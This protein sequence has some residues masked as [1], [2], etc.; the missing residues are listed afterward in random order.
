MRNIVAVLLTS[1]ALLVGAGTSCAEPVELRCE[2]LVNPLG[3]DAA[4]PRFSWQS[5]STER[6]WRQTAYEILVSTKPELLK[7]GAADV[8]ESG[9]VKSG[10]SLGIV[11]AGPKLAASRRYYWT[12]RVWD[13]HGKESGF[14]PAAW[15]ETGLLTESGWKAQWISWND[16]E[17]PA[18]R[19]A[20]QWIWMTTTGKVKPGAGVVFQRTFDLS[21]YPLRAAMFLTARSEFELTVNG[22][23]VAR[24]HNWI[25]FDRQ[26]IGYLLHAG[27]NVVEVMVKTEEPE[28]DDADR[29]KKLEQQPI[30]AGLLKITQG[31]GQILRLGTDETWEVRESRTEAG[32]PA[33]V[34]NENE[35]KRFG[36]LPE[37]LPRPAAL[38]RREFELKK[39]VKSARMYATALGSYRLFA[40]GRRVGEGVLTP[41]SSDY[42][43]RVLY[44]TYDVTGLLKRGKN[45]LGAML[46]DGWYG[47]GFTWEGDHYFPQPD[48][49]LAQLEVEYADGT[50]EQI[51][52]DGK[53][54]AAASAILHSEIYAG[55]TYDARLE[56]G[57]WDAAGFDDKKWSA[58]NV[59]PAAAQ[60]AVTSQVDAAA[61]VVKSLP[62][63]TVTTM[64]DGSYVFDLGQNMVGWTKLKVKGPGGTAVRL[65]YAEVLN[66]DG[67]IYRENLRNAD[68]TDLYVLRGGETEAYEPHFTFHGFRYVE[69]NGYPGKPGLDAIEGRVV[70]SL[71]GAGTG[72]LNTSSELVNRMWAI[73]L[74]GQRGNFV[75]IP[76]DCPQRDERLGW[77]GDAAAF[78]RTGTYNF[79]IEAFSEKWLQDVRDAQLGNGSFTNVSPNT[80]P[81][82]KDNGAPGWGDA[83][84]IVPYTTWLQ[85]GNGRAIEENWAAME[86]WMQFIEKANP[87]YLR[88]HALG[89]NYSD[90]LAPDERTPSD[91]VATAYWALVAERMEEMARAAGKYEAEK[92]YAG[93][94]EKI[95]AAY[96]TAYVKSDGTVSGGTQTAYVLT[97]QMHLA[98]NELE[99]VMVNNLVK[100]IEARGEHLSTGFL[101]TPF[102]LFVLSDHGRSDVA[103]KL[104]L[105]ETYPSWGYMLSK[106]ATTWWERWDGDTGNPSMNSYNHYA[107]GSVVAWVYRKV[108]GIDTVPAGAGFHEIVI[109]PLID[110]R[111]TQALGEYDSAYGK[112]VSDWKG[113]KQGPFF[114]HV[115]IP[116]NTTARVYLPD[117]AGG[118]AKL[119]GKAVKAEV[120]GGVSVGAGDY[121]FEVK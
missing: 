17:E 107:F 84:V 47:S 40:N 98:P 76:T 18:D 11:Y 68:A 88:K 33:S 74:W 100:E 78:W 91:M 86:R 38:L 111:M 51:V 13:A 58:A 104:L 90:W 21:A 66:P 1:V 105:T 116:A 77:M 96:Q 60:M 35:V 39:N 24:K 45:V 81:F 32:K 55:E 79:D 22:K 36:K 9:R 34:A 50:R 12:V 73:G 70:S 43:T 120:D 69:V 61:S 109:R 63:K 6:D 106:G 27:K 119:E 62:A 71:R 23:E 97:L 54:R 82:D 49:L 112:I 93:L 29:A 59:T 72:K 10:E 75:T 14:A 110:E 108:A 85:Y 7:N 41:G 114:L 117:I 80:L 121:T 52:T 20:A 113:T 115:T 48:R 101:G 26:E 57:G 53:W 83:G 102:L 99:A 16:S 103:Y 65:R 31:D 87:D 2:H 64:P 37:S 95:R 30:L 5:N 8:W 94:I 92:R 19:G 67:T 3:I 15:W 25:S 118:T 89:P 56:Q 44:Q 28:A 42:R 4:A 46:G